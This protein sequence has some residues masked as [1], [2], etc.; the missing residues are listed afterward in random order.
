MAHS[1][2]AWSPLPWGSPRSW[3][4]SPRYS[5]IT[6]N[7]IRLESDETVVLEAHD[8]AADTPVSVTIH[9][10]PAKKQVLFSEKLV[11]TRATGYLGNVTFKVGADWSR[12]G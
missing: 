4:P 3:I 2:E 6:P 12:V 7:I 11:L 10:F 8:V 9:D 5:I 1:G